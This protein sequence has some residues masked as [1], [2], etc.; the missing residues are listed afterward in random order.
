MA[1]ISEDHFIIHESFQQN[2]CLYS[3]Y[4]EVKFREI[5]SVVG[6]LE[7]L[8]EIGTLGEKKLSYRMTKFY[9]WHSCRLELARALYNSVDYLFINRHVFLEDKQL[10]RAII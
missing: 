10:V 3:E 7:L 9:P 5:L 8:P 1:V 2:I 4:N 6:L